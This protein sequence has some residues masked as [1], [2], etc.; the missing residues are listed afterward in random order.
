MFKSLIEFRNKVSSFSLEKLVSNWF[1]ADRV[2]Q[3]VPKW[4]VMKIQQSSFDFLWRTHELWIR[5]ETTYGGHWPIVTGYAYNKR[6]NVVSVASSVTTE[7]VVGASG[8]SN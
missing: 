5:E 6:G 7:E 4:T 2:I 1:E 3:S 8:L